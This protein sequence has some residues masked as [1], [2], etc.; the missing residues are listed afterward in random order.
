MSVSRKHA[1]RQFLRSDW[2]S[3][4]RIAA[5]AFHGQGCCV[6][7]K[8]SIS[9]DIHHIKYPKTWR[10]TKFHHVVVMCRQHHEEVHKLMDRFPTF[11]RNKIV[12][13]MAKNH[14]DF[15]RIINQMSRGGFIACEIYTDRILFRKACN[16]VLTMNI[17]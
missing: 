4:F 10:E 11:S 7:G 13:D 9:N 17:S 12:R 16:K 8:K 2:W 14:H 3:D 5:M 1:Y 6:C 15:H